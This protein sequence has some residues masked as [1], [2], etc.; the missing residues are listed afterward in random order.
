MSPSQSAVIDAV[1]RLQADR[2]ALRQLLAHV[3][4]GHTQTSRDDTALVLIPASVM[5][6]IQRV[7]N[8]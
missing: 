4:E 3:V 8:G 1:E 6:E 2:E 5:V 7:V